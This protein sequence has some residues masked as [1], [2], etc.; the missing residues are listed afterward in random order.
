[1]TNKGTHFL[2]YALP[3]ALSLASCTPRVLTVERTKTQ[4]RD[5]HTHD[6]IYL[7]DSIYIDRYTKGDTVYLERTVT[8]RLER[9]RIDTLRLVKTDSIPYPVEV[10]RERGDSLAERITVAA[11]AIAAALLLALCLLWRWRR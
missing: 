4:W 8:R 5:R 10:T 6:S 11:I 2:I 9:W 7:H 3:L 1:M